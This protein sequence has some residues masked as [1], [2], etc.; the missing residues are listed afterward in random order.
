MV[1]VYGAHLCGFGFQV[2]FLEQQNQVLQSKWEL[3]QQ[4]D[5]NN[6]KRSLEPVYEAHISSL[7]KQLETLSRERVWLDSGPRNTREVVEDYKKRYE[8]E[9]TQHTAVEN[10]LVL[11]KKARPEGD[12]PA[13][14]S[15]Q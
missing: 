8:V 10:E 2:R 4:L 6:S 12:C 13:L 1:Y 5:L 7:C 11:L 9:I 14:D 3:L 15:C